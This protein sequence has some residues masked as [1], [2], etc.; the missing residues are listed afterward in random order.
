VITDSGPGASSVRQWPQ[1]Q[2]QIVRHLDK[3]D[4]VPIDV[5][6]FEPGQVAQVRQFIEDNQLGPRVFILE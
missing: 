4:W 2:Y 3:A 1:L 6:R 5:S